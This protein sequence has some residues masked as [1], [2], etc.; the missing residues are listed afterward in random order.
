MKQMLETILG[1]L[2]L[3]VP[4]NIIGYCPFFDKLKMKKRTLYIVTGVIIALFTLLSCTAMYYGYELRVIEYV[5]AAILGILYFVSVREQLSKLVFF[6]I[7]VLD[8]MLVIRGCAMFI[9]SKLQ[10][11]DGIVSY[12]LKGSIIHMIC[13]AVTLPFILKILHD[14]EEDIRDDDVPEIWRTIWIIPALTTFLVLMFTGDIANAEIFTP[15]FIIA[16]I[17]VLLY[18]IYI[19]MKMTSSI[20]ELKGRIMLEEEAKYTQHII[21]LQKEQY[22]AMNKHIEETRAARHDLRQHMRIIESYANSGDNE[23]ILKYIHSYSNTLLKNQPKI[24]CGNTA[25]NAIVGYY[26]EFAENE[27]IEYLTDIYAPGNIGIPD[28]D[29]CVVL[30]NL[31]ENAMEACRRIEEGRRYIDIHI[32][33]ARGKSLA[34]VVDNSSAYAPDKGRYGLKSSKHEGKG[35]GT[36]LVKTIAAQY[37]GMAQFDYKDGIFTSSVLM[38][39]PKE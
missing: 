5:F 2:V 24:Y 6:Y 35:I 27:G 16:R 17:C 20:K 36:G 3:T 12:T 25:V 29:V 1:T 33:L 15:K 23:A 32:R 4:Y 38:N 9:E 30:G 13:I 8:Y 34:I 21:K 18:M 37:K 26:A 31:I 22:I 7:F 39:I 28:T 10:S 14:T 11:F 19:Y